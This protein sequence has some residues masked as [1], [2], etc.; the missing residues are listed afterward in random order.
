MIYPDPNYRQASAYEYGTVHDIHLSA[1]VHEDIIWGYSYVRADGT[2]MGCGGFPG[3]FEALAHALYRI[4]K[5]AKETHVSIPHGLPQGYM[6][7]VANNEIYI[8]S[9][10]R[11]VVTKETGQRTY[12]KGLDEK[13]FQS[14]RTFAWSFHDGNDRE[15]E[16]EVSES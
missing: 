7:E 15:Y 10:G 12:V 13:S 2:G 9:N 5:E 8:K 16:L 14:A 6:L 3:P 1:I 4:E 11:Y